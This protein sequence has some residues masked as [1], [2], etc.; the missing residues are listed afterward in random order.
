MNSNAMPSAT[1]HFQKRP[2]GSR[3]SRIVVA[4]ITVRAD[5]R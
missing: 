1:G 2:L 3:M 5:A 4:A